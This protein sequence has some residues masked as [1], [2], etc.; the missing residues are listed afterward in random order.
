MNRMN[1]PGFTADA[2]LYKTRGRYQSVATGVDSRGDNK[3]ISQDR[4][5]AQHVV[6]TLGI[7]AVH[8]DTKRTCMGYTDYP[9]G[10]G[11]T[12]RTC[13]GGYMEVEVEPCYWW[14]W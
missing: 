4:Q 2:S 13:T 10:D 3:I 7:G 9:T 12:M 8:C 5:S 14:P 1:M 11:R 6:N